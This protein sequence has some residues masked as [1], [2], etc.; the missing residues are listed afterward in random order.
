MS[1]KLNN[2]YSVNA[3]NFVERSRKANLGANGKY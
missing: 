3:C 2:E 1:Q